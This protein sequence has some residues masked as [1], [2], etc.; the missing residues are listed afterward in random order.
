MQSQNASTSGLGQIIS[1]IYGMFNNPGEAAV[2]DLDKFQGNMQPFYQ[3]YMDAGKYGINTLQNDLIPH[4]LQML[5]NPAGLANSFGQSYQQSPGYQW[6]TSQA[7]GAANR[8]AAAG[9]MLGSPAE[10]QM[11][12]QNINGIAN[13]DYN[14]Y[15]DRIMSLYGS[16]LSNMSN[17]GQ[18]MMNT[19]AQATNSFGTNLALALLAKA[20]AQSA[21]SQAA[22]DSFGGLMG[23]ITG[24]LD[25]GN[26]QNMMG[27]MGGAG[28][29]ASLAAL[30]I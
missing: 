5:N 23:G 12:A 1:S 18:S 17:V 27:S 26:P 14:D 24:M 30:F 7:T 8:A 2:K 15:E 20:K 29:L 19:G 28:G 13:Q 4:L 9:G 11:L 22:S 3:P 21:K 16:G 6:K 10:Q 25:Q